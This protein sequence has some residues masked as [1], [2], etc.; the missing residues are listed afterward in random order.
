MVEEKRKEL[1]L[2]SVTMKVLLHNLRERAPK[3][4]VGNDEGII[5]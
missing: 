2:R 4:K 1:N 3:T 5:A